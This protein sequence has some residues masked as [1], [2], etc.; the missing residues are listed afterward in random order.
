MSEKTD[1]TCGFAGF[2]C[3]CREG[4]NVQDD[5]WTIISS[6]WDE[7]ENDMASLALGLRPW[8]FEHR[9][10]SFNCARFGLR[11]LSNLYMAML[12]CTPRTE[13]FPSQHGS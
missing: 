12:S 13:N 8:Y 3:P 2:V 9:E 10:R 1:E 5:A 6:S 4:M 7:K 11:T